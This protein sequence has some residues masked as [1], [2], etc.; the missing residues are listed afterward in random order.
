MIM[1][2]KVKIESVLHTEYGEMLKMRA[3]SRSVAYPADGSDEDN[4]YSKF[5]P[6]AS[7]E[8][9]VNNPALFGQFSPGEKYYVDFTKT[10][11]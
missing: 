2:A 3:V 9:T 10:E 11:S 8:I 6:S 1:R 4:T 5:T 7:L